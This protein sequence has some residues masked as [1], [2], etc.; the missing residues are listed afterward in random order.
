MKLEDLK[1]LAGCVTEPVTADHLAALRE[2]MRQMG[3]DPDNVYQE[4]EM[5]DAHV[6]VHRDTSFDNAAIQ[7]HS[8]SFYEILCCRNSC[9]AEYLVGA[10]RYCLQKGDLIFVPPGISHRPLLSDRMEEPYVRDV[11]W[12][13]EEFVRTLQAEFGRNEPRPRKGGSLLRTAGTRWEYLGGMLRDAIGEAEQQGADWE[14]AVAGRAMVFM[15]HL[16][17][18][19]LESKIPVEAERPDLLEQIL[20]YVE[21]HLAER[22]TL[23]DMAK[24]FYVSESTVSK[25]FRRKMG[26]SFYRCVTQRR[27]IAA[28]QLIADGCV[29]EE[30]AAAAGFSDYSAFYRAF[31][32]E[33][34]ISPRQYR[35]LQN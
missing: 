11:L 10:E 19:F 22:I 17:R 35:M 13:S 33:Y 27:L 6:Q 30:V 34:G 2:Q 12:I 23:S 9:G 20:A 8:H 31:R 28:K 32:Q 18:A 7:L 21:D 26:V 1:R 4:L 14:I 3:L 24:R 29:L 16:K 15:S 5:S 25:T